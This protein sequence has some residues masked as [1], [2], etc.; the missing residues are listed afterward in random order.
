MVEIV[1]IILSAGESTRFVDGNKLLAPYRGRALVE[2]AVS[3]LQVDPIDRLIAIVGHDSERITAVLEEEVDEIRFNPNYREGLSTSVL[4]GATAA[5]RH[6]AT[7][8][9]FMPGDMPCVAT[10]TVSQVVET[11]ARGHGQI[12]IPTYGSIRGNPV[13]FGAE[14]F[15]AL[16]GL[17][18]D[19]GGRQLFDSER[20]HRLT[21]DD[22]GIRIAID[23]AEDLQEIRAIGC[24]EELLRKEDE[25]AIE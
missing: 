5:R 14:H 17:S 21:V 1:G 24:G 11:F 9:V 13:L 15:D 10:S 22:P 4:V 6:G 20:A 25:R 7:G 19:V 18:G 8:A 12:I 23:T 2:H 3:S 16:A